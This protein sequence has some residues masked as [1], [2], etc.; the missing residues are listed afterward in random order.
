MAQ[1]H[2]GDRE[3]WEGD[4]IV[5]V[6]LGAVSIG[7]GLLCVALGLVVDTKAGGVV[8]LLCC[9]TYYIALATRER[10]GMFGQSLVSVI[11]S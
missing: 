7:A 6:V 2:T 3:A 9:A 4:W 11:L 10:L 1:Q 5:M 8:C